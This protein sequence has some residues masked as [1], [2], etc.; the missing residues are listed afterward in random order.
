MSRID[1]SNAPYYDDFDPNKGFLRVLFRPKSVQARELTQAQTILQEQINRLGSHLFEEGSMVVPGGVSFDATQQYVKITFIGESEITDILDRENMTLV[2]TGSGLTAKVS[3]V[4]PAVGTDPATVL[5]KYL[6]S[7]SDNQTKTFSPDES[8]RFNITSSEGVT[9]AIANARCDE[10]GKGSWAQVAAGVY[11]VRGFMVQNATQDLVVSKYSTTPSARIGFSIVESI[12]TEDEDDTLFSNAQGTPNF[13]APGAHRFKIELILTSKGIDETT[14]EDFIEL[15]RIQD[16][17]IETIVTNT[18]YSVLEKTLAQRTYEESG[19]YAVRPYNLDPRDHLRSIATPDG[20]FESTKGGQESLLSI[21][22]KAGLAYVRGYRVENVSTVHVPVEKARDSVLQNNAVFSAAYQNYIIITGAFSIP[23][24]DIK[25]KISLHDAAIVGGASAGTIIG[26][27]RVRAVQYLAAGS[28][29]VYL[30]DIALNAGKTFNQVKGVRYTDASS[31][32]GASV[33][34]SAVFG[35]SQN[36]MVFPVNYSA[37][38][39]LKPN[40]TSDT[41]YS[42]TRQYD[43][44]TNASGVATLSLS[45][46]ELFQVP[47]Q[48]ECFAVVHGPANTGGAVAWAANLFVLGGTPVGRSVTINSGLANTRL[49]VNMVVIKQQ[50]LEKTKT[51]VTKVDMITFTN[52]S[53]RPLTKCDGFKLNSVVHDATGVVV[54]SG[55]KFDGGQRDNGYQVAN[56]TSLSGNLTG[57]YQVTYEY[58][59]HSQ[60]DYFSVD[61]YSDVSYVDIPTH[62]SSDGVSYELSDCLDFR[63]LF[64]TAGDITASTFAGDIIRP[65]DA[66]RA[67]VVFYLPRVDTLYVS[68]D[69]NFGAVKG[70]PDLLPTAPDV[71]SDSM[72]IAELSIPAYTF[73]PE[74]VR[75]SLVDNR[76]YTMRD[77]GKLEK[78][79][80]TLEYYTTLSSLESTVNKTQVTDPVTGNDRFKNGFATEGFVDFSLSDVD[81]DEYRFALDFEKNVGEPEFD[82]FAT[83]MKFASGANHSIGT[84]IVAKSY[85]SV[86]SLKQPYATMSIN[87]NPFAVY[88]WAGNITLN[89]S[90]D[91]WKDVFY[92]APILVNSTVN[93]RGMAKEGAVSKSW[94]SGGKHDR[95]LNK[96]VTTTTFTENTTVTVDDKFLT[97]IVYTFMRAIDISFVGSCLRP[98]TRVY[99]FFEN[100]DVSAYCRPAGGTNGQALV[101]D[102]NGTI[103]G[104]F[105]VPNSKALSFRTGTNTFRL[106]DSQVDSRSP[107]VLTTEAQTN[108]VSGGS[109]DLRQQTITSTRVL[110]YDE[111]TVQSRRHYPDPIAQTF[112]VTSQG[113]EYLT[114]IDIFM[115][116]KS[117]TI[118]LRV[119]LRAVENGYPTNTL[120]PFG[121]KVLQPSQVNI[122]ESANVA[123]HVQFDELVYIEPGREYAIV[124]LADTQEYNAWISE[125]GGVVVGST[126]TVS[127][128]PSLGSFF[129]SQNSSTWT[130]NQNQDL[131][132]TLY[133]AKFNLSDTVVTF[134]CQAPQVRPAMRFNP[135]STTT[136][137]SSVTLVVSASGL[138]NGDKFTVSGAVGGNGIASS[139]LNKEHTATSV[140]DNTITFSPGIAAT[141]TGTIG[142]DSVGVI[143]N[144]PYTLHYTTVNTL[145]LEGTS[146]EWSAVTKNQSNRGFNAGVGF[147][148]DN[149]VPLAEEGVILAAGDFKLVATLKSTRDNLSPIIDCDGF[150]VALIDYR[151][152]NNASSPLCQYV[153]REVKFDTPSTSARMYVGA[154][155]P[156]SNTM[157][158]YYKPVT[159]GGSLDSV[160]WVEL[161]PDTPLVNDDSKFQEYTYRIENIGS[162]SGFKVK[163]ALLG[164]NPCVRPQL[165]D[166]RAIALA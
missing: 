157:K 19:D 8:L 40:G 117:S 31:L 74:D 161:T 116:T 24:S 7:G 147:V 115:R 81:N 114:G 41:T 52:H 62:V 43:V 38:K 49:L 13:K 90:T 135:F 22:V 18:D 77:I 107:N 153:T 33:T 158:F 118:P 139:A 48:T 16:G 165:S 88:A 46:N 65:S 42:V 51:K 69:G 25:K 85:T 136:G 82:Q 64:D 152:N 138:K 36:I 123:T 32:F 101:T 21:G 35:S 94:W 166:F 9:Q 108:H 47:N 154:K 34:Q 131:K 100:I 105:S 2:S 150:G 78:R 71:P 75:I 1:T 50:P 137:S 59:E 146:I 97:N 91:F 30:F 129:V 73:S 23:Q 86:V 163:I 4:I 28:Y 141:A 111:K 113:G 149:D 148:P 79:I 56:L 89:P 76:R 106:T 63:P 142:G 125:M 127:S 3:K 54:T 44:T 83:D 109:Y 102:V 53:T 17:V 99:P 12:V 58:F 61:S 156:G 92:V 5:V 143:A 130:A 155:L 140:T 10:T 15:A 11:F 45:T 29:K 110:S 98:Y 119:E 95:F 14:D 60:G 70:I 84:D 27:A 144:Y 37:V 133:R 112:W 96:I 145:V 162:F 6:N 132:F 67:D 26:T 20:I 104:V 128:Q 57:L 159:T 93:N 80:E 164:T 160:A 122:S 66:I 121:S 55:F 151:L 124:L 134:N 72:K 120:I 68:A 103:R 39:T 87:V 126:R